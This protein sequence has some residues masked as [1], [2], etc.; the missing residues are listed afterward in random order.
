VYERDPLVVAIARKRADHRC[1][2]RNCA[3]LSFETADG[4]AYVEIHH[5]DP[6]ADGG[7]DTIENVA[8]LCPLHH[9]EVHLGKKAKELKAQ[10]K[11]LRLP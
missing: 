3:H 8:C 5:I 11:A 6:L 9:R 10:L 7:E 1:E 4:F 2:V